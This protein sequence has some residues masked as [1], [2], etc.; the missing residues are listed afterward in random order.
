MSKKPNWSRPLRLLTAR[1]CG[2]GL[3]LLA[4]QRLRIAR[5]KR[6]EHTMSEVGQCERTFWLA[7]T[8]SVNA[9]GVRPHSS[10]AMGLLIWS[11][12]TLDGSL[13]AALIIRAGLARSA[14]IV[15]GKSTTVG[16]ERA[17][18]NG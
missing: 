15:I 4:E 2:V 11:R 9:A 17:L 8:G 16:M 10:V 13:M 14:P 3:S 7:P 18:T 1:K 12:I 5:L 6:N